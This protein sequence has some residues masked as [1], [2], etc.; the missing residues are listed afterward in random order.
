MNISDTAA[1]KLIK[2]YQLIPHPEGGWYREVHRSDHNVNRSDGEQR[3]ALTMI[4]FLLQGGDISRWHRVAA[5][6][7]T[8]H[9][10]GGDAKSR[11]RFIW[12]ADPNSSLA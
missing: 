10:I 2:R 3:S 6:D 7:E 1:N 4:L 5:A 11:C 9:F 12:A 8:W